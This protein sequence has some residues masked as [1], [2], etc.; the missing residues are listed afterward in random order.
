LREGGER[1]GYGGCFNGSKGWWRNEVED[2]GSPASCPME[3]TYLL[4]IPSCVLAWHLTLAAL[5][6]SQALVMR[7]ARGAA[8]PG[9]G[10]A[11]V[12][13]SIVSSSV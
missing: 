13:A 6:A 9:T 7:G 11:G 12:R 3:P 4:H 8:W 5:Q 1:L 10:A 2:G